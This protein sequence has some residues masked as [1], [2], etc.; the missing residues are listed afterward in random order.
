MTKKILDTLSSL[1]SITYDVYYTIESLESIGL[2]VDDSDGI[3]KSLYQA[4]TTS[5]NMILDTIYVAH[6]NEKVTNKLAEIRTFV[7]H[8]DKK[9]FINRYIEIC[10]QA[11]IFNGHF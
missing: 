10:K 8:I 9:D 4:L 2:N 7:K 5:E 6:D 1:A 11:A 3:G